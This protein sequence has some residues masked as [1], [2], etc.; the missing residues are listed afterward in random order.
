MRE[1]NENGTLNPY[2]LN[3]F[4]MHSGDRGG[5]KV[6]Y[7]VW[8]EDTWCAYRGLTDWDD[9]DV[10]ARGEVIPFEAAKILF[11]TVAARYENYENW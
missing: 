1:I 6:C 9:S 8:S 4:E 2:V 11:S 5:Y 3:G 10:V 7:K